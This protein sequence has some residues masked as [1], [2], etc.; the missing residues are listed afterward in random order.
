MN[1][2]EKEHLSAVAGLGC[3]LCRRMGYFDTPCEIHHIREVGTG[4]CLRSSHMTAIGL[5]PEHHRG[6]TGFHGLGR[7]AF[8]RKYGLTQADLLADV[9]NALDDGK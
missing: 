5:C 3:M 9:F 2:A 1:K 7:K 6:A 4:A 8:E